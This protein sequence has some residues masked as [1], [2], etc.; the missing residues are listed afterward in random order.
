MMVLAT[1]QRMAPTLRPRAITDDLAS[2]ARR[3]R[4]VPL[5]A[6]VRPGAA[7]LNRQQ[8]NGGDAC[9]NHRPLHSCM[10]VVYAMLMPKRSLPSS[11]GGA[12]GTLA[13]PSF[14]GP[15]R[16]VWEQLKHKW[17]EIGTACEHWPAGR[18]DTETKALR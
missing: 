7:R 15:D 3:S 4:R 1:C 2:A 8:D 10:L 14:Q 13:A 5:H 6:I 9:Q 12:V 16:S 18:G 17:A 11:S